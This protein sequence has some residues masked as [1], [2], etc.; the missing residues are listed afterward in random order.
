MPSSDK[1]D[2]QPMA[3]I[4]NFVDL[5]VKVDFCHNLC[6]LSYIGFSGELYFSKTVSQLQSTLIFG[7]YSDS[8]FTK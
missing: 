1:N 3:A 2:V 7:D 6:C 8:Y 5:V 4:L